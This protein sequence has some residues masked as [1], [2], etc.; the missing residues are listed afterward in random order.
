M[1]QSNRAREASLVRMTK[2]AILT[3]CLAIASSAVLG[4][5]TP[6][7]LTAIPVP[8]ALAL[9]APPP[10]VSPQQHLDEAQRGLAGISEKSVALRSQKVFGK[11]VKD[12]SALA[13]GYADAKPETSDWTPTF[14]NV[15]RDL[16]LL[17]GAGGARPTPA[18]DVKGSRAAHVEAL[19]SA[20]R[21][22][23]ETVR[24][25]VELFYDATTTQGTSAIAAAGR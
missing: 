1:R 6:D 7:M 10:H 11:L 12:V 4:A 15:E 3:G 8:I 19:D 5:Q 24:T 16:V 18:D 23:L 22:V 2:L 17:I 25:N 9:A 21:I 14:S 20:I 13:T